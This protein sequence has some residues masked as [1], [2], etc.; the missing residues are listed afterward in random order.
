MPL[1]ALVL[2]FAAAGILAA[3]G[4]VSVYAGEA[5]AALAALFKEHLEQSFRMRPMEATQLGD[6]RFDDRLDDLSAAA[7][8]RWVEHAQATL[9]ALPRRVDAAKLS[10]AGK[11]DYAIFQQALVQSLWSAENT[12]PFEEDP[13]VYNGYITDSIYKPLTQSTRPKEDRVTACIAR[14]RQI[15]KIIAAAKEN[16]RRPLR[17][18][19]ETAVRQNRGAIAFYESELFD[20][21]GHS[22]QMPALKEAAAPVVAWLKDYQAYLENDALPRSGDHWRLG[23]ERFARKLAMELD[24]G[25]SAAEVLREADAEFARVTRE[26]YVVA[27]Q[28]WGRYYPGKALPPDDEAGRR[29]ATALVLEAVCRDHSRPEEL[30]RDVKA[31]VARI[32]KFIAERNILRLPEPDRCQIIEMPE[33]QRATRRRF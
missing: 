12:H 27:R 29:R 20:I 25:M 2:S 21:V 16:L 1:K 22:P 7:R 8:R 3:A 15:D 13:R 19:T 9:D 4:S 6:H 31:T 28:L 10:P 11:I 33:F 23:K 32:R 14:M 24:G 18:H 30:T 17:T 26:M 5:D